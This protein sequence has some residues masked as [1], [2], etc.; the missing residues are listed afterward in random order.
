[1]CFFAE[2]DIDRIPDR[3]QMYQWLNMWGNLTHGARAMH[4]FPIWLQILPKILFK[5]INK[6]GKC[7]NYKIKNTFNYLIILF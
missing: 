6:R 5:V 1:M 4:H 7:L 2:F 3:V